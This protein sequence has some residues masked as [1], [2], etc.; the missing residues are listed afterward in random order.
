[1]HQ[2][3][4]NDSALL[5]FDLMIL[6]VTCDTSRREEFQRLRRHNGA[7]D[8]PVNHDVTDR[9]SPFNTGFL[10]DDQGAITPALA[11]DAPSLLPLGT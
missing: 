6:D 11:A 4:L 7:D 10:A 5:H 3:P 1:M 2:P 8:D 9:D